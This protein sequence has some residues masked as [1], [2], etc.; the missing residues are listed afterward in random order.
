MVIKVLIE[1]SKLNNSFLCE[2][3]LSLYIE[4]NR[5]KIL[6][7]FGQTDSLFENAKTLGVDLSSV[8]IA[9]LSHAH[10][11]HS[12]G[13]KTFLKVNKTAKIYVSSL[14]FGNYFNGETKYIGVD[15]DL[16]PSS[17]IITIDDTLTIDDELTFYSSSLVRGSVFP[18]N[19]TVKTENGYVLDDFSHEYYLQITENA[20]KVLFSGCSHKNIINIIKAFPCDVFVGGLHFSKIDLS[21]VE[22]FKSVAKTLSENSKLIYAGHCSGDAQFDILKKYLGDK[23]QNLSS[24][25][26][27]KIL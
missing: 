25:Q 24:G 23:L 13:L 1:N 5:H 10:Y 9:F 2:H 27:I 18:Q 14:V 11:D 12:G 22:F 8:D 6:Y 21:Q 15:K 17:R 4:T 3:G 20:K 7:D 19:L 26:I 16:F